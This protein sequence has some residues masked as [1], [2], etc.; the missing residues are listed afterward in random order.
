[1]E[2][3]TVEFNLEEIEKCHNELIDL[4]LKRLLQNYQ[5]NIRQTLESLAVSLILISYG[6]R[7]GRYFRY[8]LEGLI[9]TKNVG[10]EKTQKAK[11]EVEAYIDTKFKEEGRLHVLDGQREIEK[12]R[13]ELPLLDNALKNEALN[14]LINHWTMFEATIRDLWIFCLNSHS[15]SFLFNVLKSDTGD[16]DGISGKNIS[17]G[18]LAKYNF[19][20]SKNLGEILVQKF[21][22]TTVSGIK[23]SFKI[24]FE[25]NES[26]LIMFENENLQQLEILRHLIVHN[27]GTIDNEYLKRTKRKDEK[28]GDRVTLTDKQLSGY[29]NAGIYTTTRLFKLA[30]EKI[31]NCYMSIASS[32]A[33]QCNISYVQTSAVVGARRI[34]PS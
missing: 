15:K 17:I 25:L 21:D 19:N 23:K 18:L 12:L 24:L 32:G 33:G 9:A 20:I 34:K 11:A 5:T 3:E 6:L 14:T 1:M 31:N 4:E 2:S 29:C 8:W 22:F 13:T 7:K 26:E 10:K 27:A 30:D 28:L 16:I